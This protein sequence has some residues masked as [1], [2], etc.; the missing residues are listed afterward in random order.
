[1]SFMREPD[2]LPD[3]LVEAMAATLASIPD[4][5]QELNRLRAENA[6]LKGKLVRLVNALAPKQDAAE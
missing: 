2:L 5:R 1:M 3:R 6:E 4:M